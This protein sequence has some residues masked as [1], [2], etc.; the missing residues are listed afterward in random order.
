LKNQEAFID[1][2]FNKGWYVL[3]ENLQFDSN[4]SQNI[5]NKIEDGKILLRK[6]HSY[7]CHY[8]EQKKLLK[9]TNPHNTQEIIYIN[10]NYIGEYAR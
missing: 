1:I 6:G 3:N 8:D 9:I 7:A 10:P 2:S 5:K 4:G